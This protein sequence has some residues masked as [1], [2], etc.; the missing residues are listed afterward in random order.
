M[1]QVS[2]YHGLC[3]IE[4][5][6][7]PHP[8]WLFVGNVHDIP[9][10]PWTAAPFG[11]TVRCAPTHKYV[12]GLPSEHRLQYSEIYGII[13][14]WVQKQ[15]SDLFV[16]YPSWKFMSAGCVLVTPS[17]CVIEAVRGELA[18]LLRGTKSPD[19]SYSCEGAML[20]HV[21]VLFGD[22]T[23]L[24]SADLLVLR[25]AALRLVTT[26]RVVLEW[27]KTSEG[28]ILFHDWYEETSNWINQSSLQ[29]Q[30]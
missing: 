24:S 13:R 14:S 7:L 25:Q 28:N 11:W 6:E 29:R 18:P 4:T 22:P 21:S 16:V 17:N 9:G 12:F 3:K 10:V 15:Y 20:L 30:E 27:S 2:R 5:S 26:E 19:A 1:Q 23:V 8:R